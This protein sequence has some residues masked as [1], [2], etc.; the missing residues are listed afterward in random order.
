MCWRA[1][2]L[3]GVMQGPFFDVSTTD[4]ATFVVAPVLL[5]AVSLLASWRPARRA[6]RVSPVEALRSG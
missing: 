1:I 5:A 6:S 2:G 3:F 4:P